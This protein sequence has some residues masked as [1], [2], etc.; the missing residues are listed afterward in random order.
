[1]LFDEG[2]FT[3]YHHRC[4]ERLNVP[5]KI[6]WTLHKEYGALNQGHSLATDNYYTDIHLSIALLDRDSDTIGTVRKGRRDL[7][8]SVL[9]A[10]FQVKGDKIFYM[11]D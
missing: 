8:N 6:V 1:M 10:T 9:K 5:G 11:T 7:P 4:P 3:R 2:K